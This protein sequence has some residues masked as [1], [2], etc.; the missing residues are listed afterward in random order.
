[1]AHHPLCLTCSVALAENLAVS[2][3]A[4]TK[5]TIETILKEL[6][7]FRI[8]TEARF[9]GIEKHLSTIETQLENIDMR[10]DGIES[11]A[12]QTRSEVLALRKEFKELRA[13]FK[14]PA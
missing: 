9:S 6:R 7:E 11:F 3:E 8:L 2:D 10:L 1:M 5:P 12:H 13:Q 4:P 14:E